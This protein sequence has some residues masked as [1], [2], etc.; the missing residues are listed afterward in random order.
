MTKYAKGAVLGALL[1]VSSTPAIAADSATSVDKTFYS[2]LLDYMQAQLAYS[3]AQQNSF[4]A[5]DKLG[6]DTAQLRVTMQK[7]L[8]SQA[9]L[10]AYLETA[11]TV[12]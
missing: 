1:A 5:L 7:M 10:I 9:S 3:G 6:V 12:A 11:I 2:Y 8:V 4:D